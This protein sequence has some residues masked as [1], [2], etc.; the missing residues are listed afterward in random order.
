MQ[1]EQRPWAPQQNP[2]PRRGL[3][4]W[5]T[6][7][8][9]VGGLFVGAVAGAAG[10]G[11]TTTT[12]PRTVSSPSPVYIT[13]PASAPAPPPTTAAGVPTKTTAAPVTVE[14]GTWTVGLD[15]PAGRYRTTAAVD[16]SCNWAIYKSGT[17]GDDIIAIDIPGGGRPVVTVKKGQD[18]HTSGCGTWVRIGS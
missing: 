8:A 6:L 11:S 17:N 10:A 12:T 3:P 2:A 7:I 4:W 16:S 1:P 14:D 15:I 9:G 13:V 18:F 5:V